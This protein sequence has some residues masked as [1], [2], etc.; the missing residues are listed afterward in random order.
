MGE[1]VVWVLEEVVNVLVTAEKKL[2]SLANYND[3]D[4]KNVT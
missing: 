1:N 4:Y 2:R 3:D